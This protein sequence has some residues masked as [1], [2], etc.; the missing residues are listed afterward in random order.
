MTDVIST[1]AGVW[2]A[3]EIVLTIGGAEIDNYNSFVYEGDEDIAS[4]I[5]CSKGTA[6][7]QYKGSQPKATLKVKTLCSALER[8][9]EIRDGKEQVEVV[10]QTPVKVAN[11]ITCIIASIKDGEDAN[12][13][14]EATVEILCMKIT[15]RRV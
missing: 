12:G 5:E 6:G 10:Y 1:T 4:H 14:P 11:L 9:Y 2:D 15:T 8:L 7:F 13:A 3:N